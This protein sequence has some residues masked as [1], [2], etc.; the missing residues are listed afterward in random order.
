MFNSWI[1]YGIFYGFSDD[2][3]IHF[4]RRKLDPS[5]KEPQTPVNGK[6]FGTGLVLGT[7]E[8]ELP[9]EEILQGIRERRIVPEPFPNGRSAD[10]TFEEKLEFMN[11]PLFLARYKK[12]VEIIQT[13][14]GLLKRK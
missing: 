1:T 4:V 5:Y 3:I 13:Q 8:S 6:L 7:L 11:H 14:Y 9:E 2:S 12:I 10:Y